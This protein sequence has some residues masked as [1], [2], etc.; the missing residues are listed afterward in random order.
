MGGSNL[1]QHLAYFSGNDVT[2]DGKTY[3][4][5][6]GQYQRI[7][8]SS[9]TVE[10]TGLY[11]FYKS[12]DGGAWTSQSLTVQQFL[13]EEKWDIITFQQSGNSADAT[14][15]TYY[16]P[17]IYALHKSLYSKVTYPT[18]L[19][20][21]LV[22]GAYGNDHAANLTKWENGA[23]NAEKVMRETGSSILIPYGTAIQN[24]RS[25]TL[26]SLGDGSAHDLL[27]DTAHLQDGIGPLAAA[28]TYVLAIMR[29]KGLPGGV[30]GDNTRPD[31][32]FL[33]TYNVP[34]Q[35]VGTGMIGITAANCL[36]A[37]IAA[38]K[39]IMNPYEVT[40]LSVYQ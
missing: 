2:L 1:A 37:Q 35:N 29:A 36:L 19:G 4:T 40:D 25:T 10:F 39:A 38:E 6:N 5:V 12:V 16:A 14:W 8:A 17:Y 3:K 13:D 15:E 7:E 27:V 18:R 22:H 9:G 11:T 28:F 31:A 26:A 32:T 30:V 23:T 24:L 20:W 21:V 33:S 34:G